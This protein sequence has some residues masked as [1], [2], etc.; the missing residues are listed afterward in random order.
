MLGDLLGNDGVPEIAIGRLPVTTGEELQRIIGSIA[1]F[2]TNHESMDALF[3]ADESARE[4]FA[5]AARA[6]GRWVA[7]ERAREID[8]NSA[9]L[10][11]ARVDLFSTWKTSSW[12]SYVGHG[13]LDRIASEGL[14]TSTDVP[15][16]AE[17]Q[18]AP[19]VL[20]WSCNLQ[21]FDI[22]G[23]LSLGEQ[24][25]LDGASA[26]VFSA[27]G[28]SNHVETDALRSA[29]TQAVFASDAET[30]GEAMIRAHQAAREASISTHRVYMLL[31]DPALRLRAAK[32]Q[33]EP[34]LDSPPG[35]SSGDP[36]G[37]PRGA[38]PADP[39]SGCAIAPPGTRQAPFGSL[40]LTLCAIAALRVRRGRRQITQEQ[41]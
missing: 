21:R 24:L 28:W 1:S 7:P 17:L 27:T 32:A 18:N 12:L 26:G 34:E 20:A 15:A 36:S 16:L 22:P 25:L 8:L 38:E 40:L 13:G 35:D 11:E 6:L 41:P 37:T 4:E 14:L 19:V 5:A 39:A 33:A 31:G 30:I 29:F 23:G 10:E 9:S 3:V 2:E